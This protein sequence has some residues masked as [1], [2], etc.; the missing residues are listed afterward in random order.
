VGYRGG[1]DELTPVNPGAEGWLTEPGVRDRFAWQLLQRCEEGSTFARGQLEDAALSGMLPDPRWSSELRQWV[2]LEAQI[3]GL[4]ALHRPRVEEA[5]VGPSEEEL[6]AL[7]AEE[8]RLRL[9]AEELAA[10]E[11]AERVALGRRRV[12]LE[13]ESLESLGG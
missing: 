4:A 2:K 10:R 6:A 13:L 9:E 12:L 8:E 11:A 1:V 3:A 7:A 5:E